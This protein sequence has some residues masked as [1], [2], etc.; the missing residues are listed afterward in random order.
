MGGYHINIGKGWCV[1]KVDLQKT[2]DSV[3]WDFLFGTLLAIGTICKFVS[4]IRV[5]ITPPMY[6]IFINGSSFEG[7]FLGWG[8][9]CQGDPISPYLF[10]IVM[11]VLF[12]LLNFSPL[13]LDFIIVVTK[14][15]SF[16]YV[17]PMI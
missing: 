12:H 2:Y 7:Y 13:L 17:L 15:G 11:E 5:C 14:F 1:M 4:W 3:N 8:G 16:M 9:L 6:F 10:M